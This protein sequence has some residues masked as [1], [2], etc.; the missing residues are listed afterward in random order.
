MT[1]TMKTYPAL[2]AA[3]LC[4]FHAPS[5]GVAK[6]QPG[7]WVFSF[8]YGR[9]ARDVATIKSLVDTGAAHEFGDLTNIVRRK[10][11]PLQL[12]SRDRG[13]VFV[14][15][16]DFEPIRCLHYLERVRVLPGSAI[17]FPGRRA[18][19]LLDRRD[20]R[21]DTVPGVRYVSG[22]SI[23]HVADPLV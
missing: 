22:R 4:C 8:G 5:P 23:A 21:R 12:R 14:E 18:I 17:W 2:L 6:E 20:A 9:N 1:M 11:T 3:I 15:G 19:R 16:R 10:G 13:K 7:H